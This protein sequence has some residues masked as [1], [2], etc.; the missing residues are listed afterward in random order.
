MATRYRPPHVRNFQ[1][2]SSTSPR[3][4]PFSVPMNHSGNSTF[5]FM[6]TSG[7]PYSL[8]S[9]NSDFNWKDMWII[10]SGATDHMTNNSSNIHHLT[11]VHRSGVTN[12]NGDSYPITGAGSVTLTDSITLDTVLLVPSLSHNLLS[13][14]QIT[15]QFYCCVIL[16]PWCCIFQDI[17]TGEIIGRGIE[18]GG[19]YYM[20]MTTAG[21][22]RVSEVHQIQKGTSTNEEQIWLW[23][24]RLGHPSFG[25]LQTLFP[26]LFQHNK[27]SAFKCDTCILGKSHR[28]SYPLS[29]TKSIAPFDLV[30]SDVWG[31]CPPTPSG[32]KWFVLFVDDCTRMSWIY[33]LK[34]KSDVFPVFQTFHA[35]IRTQFQTPIKVLRSD[36]GGE[37]VNHLFHQYL[38]TH[39]IIH[40][41]TCPQTPQQNGVA[42]RKNRHILEVARS[43]LI[44]AHMPESFWGDAILT[45]VYLINRLPTQALQSTSK[46]TSPPPQT[47]I[48]AL[49]S[50]LPLPPTHALDPK[51][52]GCVAYV[53]IHRNQRTKLDACAEKCIFIGYASTQKGYRCYSPTTKRTYVSMDVTFHEHDLHFSPKATL[54]GENDIEEEQSSR[55]CL[56]PPLEPMDIQEHGSTGE[57]RIE[58]GNTERSNQLPT[59]EANSRIVENGNQLPTPESPVREISSPS[60]IPSTPMLPEDDPEVIN[61][62]VFEFHDNINSEPN[63]ET[64]PSHKLP[65]RKNRGQPKAQYEPDPKAKAKYPISNYMSSHRLSKSYASFVF[66]LS[67]IIIPNKVQDALA[68]RKWTKAMEEEMEALQKSQTWELVPKP[69]GKRIVGCRWIYTLKYAADGTL[70]RYKAR[71]VAKGY[72]QTY[73]IDYQETFAP[74]AKMNTVRVLLSLL[75]ANLDWPLKQF[76]VKNAFLHG[77]LKEEVYMDLPPG[78]SLPSQAGMVCKLKKSLYGLKQSPRAWFGRFSQS[79]KQFGYKQSNSDHTLFLKHRKDK[80]TALIIYVDDMIVTGN[81]LEEV[82]KLEAHLSSVFEMKD[83]G[84]LKYFLGIEVARSREGISLSQRKYVVDLLIETGLLACQPADTPMEQNHKL[85]EYPDQVPTNKER[86]QRLVGKLIYLSHTRPDIAYAVSVVSQFMHA[87]SEDHMHAVHRILRYLKTN[88]GKGIMFSKNNH[89][90]IAGYTDADWAGSITDR[91]STSE[92]KSGC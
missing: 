83:L 53:H 64:E 31:P 38:A 16:Y 49:A 28:V 42:E 55:D 69:A 58:H 92:A 59:S 86:Y 48:Q 11:S 41:T 24:K 71:L 62:P 79:M 72:T 50:H 76:D 46:E 35:M 27:P 54:Q 15:K 87:P 70:D 6:T 44:G 60:T 91:R 17:L 19:L 29:S 65:F 7:K 68:D 12:A 36:N 74:V 14:K 30:H 51:I 13:V 89:T 34:N 3:K 8:L 66:H 67:A 81:D 90:D 84:G 21:N 22:H 2:S 61:N 80:L 78:Y 45:T 40:Q 52:F 4:A 47:P 43:M 39:G 56:C 63:T 1:P 57:T 5:T 26:L 73:G 82:K 75:A 18:K 33:L 9:S 85:A 20:E 23:H 25:Y 10:D 37:Y 32:M 77:D 88:P